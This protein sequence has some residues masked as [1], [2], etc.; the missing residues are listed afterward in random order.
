MKKIKSNPV[1]LQ[2]I[3]RIKKIRE[4]KMHESEKKGILNEKL[5][6]TKKKSKKTKLAK[7]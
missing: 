2:E 4:N 7:N 5:R 1:K 3:M 6:M